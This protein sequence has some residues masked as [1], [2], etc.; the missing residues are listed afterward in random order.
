MIALDWPCPLPGGSLS[1]EYALAFDKGRSQCLMIVPALFDEGNRMRRFCADVMRRLDAS[2]ID[3]VLPDFPGTNES[4][5]PLD[6]CDTADWADAMEA[7][8]RHFAATHVLAVRGGAVFTP[9]GLPGWHYAPA[10][11]PAIL[12]QLLRARVIASREAG[13]EESRETLEAAARSDGIELAGYR[14]GADFY[15]QFESMKTPQGP[16]VI[17]QTDI[18]G[19]G[20]WLRAEPGED[21]Q[22][23][24]ALAAILVVGIQA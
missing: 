15:R 20:L 13:I 9:T 23:A 5:V 16:S 6:H 22:Q 21:R 7:A 8:A 24:D 1:R 19:S 4:L 14:I 10:K 18:G 12:R 2:G 17:Q 11:P 3:C